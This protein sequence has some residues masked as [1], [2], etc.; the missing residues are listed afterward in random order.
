MIRVPRH[1]AM[2]VRVSPAARR[3]AENAAGMGRCPVM[4]V[5]DSPAVRREAEIT[6]RAG[7][8]LGMAVR[9]RLAARLEAKAK[10]HR[11]TAVRVSPGQCP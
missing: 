10:S 1:P 3:G 2:A 5:R 4:A 11:V 9:G 8:R 7:R 6:V